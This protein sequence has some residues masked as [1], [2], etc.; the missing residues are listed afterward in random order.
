MKPLAR[1]SRASS[2]ICLRF[3]PPVEKRRPVQVAIEARPPGAGVNSSTTTCRVTTK[4]A[5]S[6]HGA[7]FAVLATSRRCSTVEL[8]T[9]SSFRDDLDSPGI[10]FYNDC[11]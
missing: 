1:C 2:S 11:Q 5:H 10:A 8:V 4:P 7:G 3:V 9:A 6:G